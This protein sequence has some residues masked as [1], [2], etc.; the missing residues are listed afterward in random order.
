VQASQTVNERPKA[1]AL[2]HAA[3]S[4]QTGTGHDLAGI[5]PISVYSPGHTS[6]GVSLATK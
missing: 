3:N 1:H 2:H 6:R 5:Q 4:N